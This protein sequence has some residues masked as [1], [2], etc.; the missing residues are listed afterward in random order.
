M[1][2]IFSY[3]KIVE[4]DSSSDEEQSVSPCMLSWSRSR[5]NTEEVATSDG[6][7]NIIPQHQQQC[8]EEQLQQQQH[9]QQQLNGKKRKFKFRTTELTKA[10]CKSSETP[11]TIKS[12]YPSSSSQNVA[13]CIW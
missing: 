11:I 8:S 5:T 13:L 2:I 12:P 7:K 10:I 9:Q 4:M 6:K 1:F 3:F